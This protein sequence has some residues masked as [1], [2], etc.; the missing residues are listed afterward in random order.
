V[1]VR[2]LH[3]PDVAFTAE[4]RQ[5]VLSIEKYYPYSIFLLC[6]SSHKTKLMAGEQA[7]KVDLQFVFLLNSCLISW[8]SESFTTINRCGENYNTK[9]LL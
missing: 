5:Q 6:F 3:Q 9:N 2:K 7:D 8:V 4:T 1:E